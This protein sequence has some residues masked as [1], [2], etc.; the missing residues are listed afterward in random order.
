M[1]ENITI[2]SL[3]DSSLLD[4]VELECYQILY[5][6]RL[7]YNERWYSSTR[8]L[9]PPPI[10]RW[11]GL[12]CCLVGLLICIFYF[13]YPSIRP[14]WVF[15]EAFLL[16][17]IVVAVF[18]Y[19]LPQIDASL[20]NWF[21]HSGAKGCK[22]LAI[23]MVAKANKL[24]PYVAEYIIKGDLILYC[25]GKDEQWQQ[26]WSRRLKGYAVM[27]KHATLLFRK[28]TSI[29]PTMLIL[30]DDEGAILSILKELGI[31][32]KTTE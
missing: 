9:R 4:K 16:F 22:R 28:P 8:F 18:F 29:Q 10:M 20:A 13:V 17:F 14:E 19:F 23:R 26:L 5:Q 27:G 12:V 25:R 21:K 1:S 30:Y 7:F 3:I 2:R 6:Q 15:A 11:L 31:S 32:Y 24:A